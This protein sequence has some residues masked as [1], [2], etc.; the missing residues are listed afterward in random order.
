MKKIKK[1]KLRPGQKLDA[2]QQQNVMA[3]GYGDWQGSC[4]CSKVG[5]SHVETCEEQKRVTDYGTALEGCLVIATGTI[6]GLTGVFGEAPSAATSTA[7][8]GTGITLIVEGKQLTDSATKTLTK[9][10]KR[11]M[12]CTQINPIAHK[13]GNETCTSTLL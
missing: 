4:F 1:L 13:A 3:A 9:T 6:I 8:I 5:N 10:W 2:L 7:L 12:H 11:T